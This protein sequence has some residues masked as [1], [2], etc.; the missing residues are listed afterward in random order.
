MNTQPA[1]SHIAAEV[2][3][4]GGRVATD[5]ADL[6]IARLKA[7]GWAIVPATGETAAFEALAELDA[8]LDLPG[9][10]DGAAVFGTQIGIEETTA[11]AEACGR[12]RAVLDWGR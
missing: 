12:A 4:S 2:V 1:R 6:I 8:V 7:D 3:A 11:L 10:P 9:D 5:V